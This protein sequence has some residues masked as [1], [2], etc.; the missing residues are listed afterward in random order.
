M[1]LLAA[2]PSTP[3]PTPTAS[4][5]LGVASVDLTGDTPVD[6]GGQHVG[7]EEFV[8]Y[9][10]K[11]PRTDLTYG[12]VNHTG[13]ISIASQEAAIASAFATWASVT[14]LT[15][16]KVPDCG[17]AFDSPNCLTPDIRIQFG[18]GDH[19]G[20]SH[21][22]DFDG[23]GGTAAHAF[24][25]PPNGAS[26][27]GDLH[28]DDSERWSTNGSAV[29]L[30]SVALHELGHAL[31]LSH[32][33]TNQCPFQT[34]ASRPIM[35]A[36]I[37]GI[38]RTVAQDDVNG[39]QTLYGLPGLSCAGRAVTVDLNEGEAP[40]GGSDVILGTPAADRI[41]SSAGADIVCGGGGN[42]YLDLGAGND[43]AVGGNGGDRILGRTG[44]DR[45]EGGAGNDRLL[46]GDGSDKVY[47]GGGADMLDGGS[48]PD[49][50]NAGTQSDSC[51]GRGGADTSTSCERRE[52]A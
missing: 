37:I 32:A 36:T 48:G 4:A 10:T 35:C 23:S 18:T 41:V 30:E 3:A 20:G 38:D 7:T 40:T 43:R 13:D 12:Y 44:N 51:F 15:F 42:D 17:Q 46:G 34:S 8:L 50:L 25:P 31:G 21:D 6:R 5:P 27:A 2:A 19:G 9:G 24:F 22:P 47:G 52:S 14:P 33:S 1:G 28:L 16:T 49:Q 39:V 11:W 29:D 26:A 45:L